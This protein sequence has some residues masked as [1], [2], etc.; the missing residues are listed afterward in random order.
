MNRILPF[1]YRILLICILSVLFF[2][3]QITAAN[4]DSL[5]MCVKIQHVEQKIKTMILLGKSYQKTNRNESNVIFKE[6]I[7][8]IPKS[9]LKQRAD[10]NYRIAYNYFKLEKHDSTIL[11]YD[12]V[13]DTYNELFDPLNNMK[14]ST[15][16][17]LS[18]QKTRDFGKAVLSFNTAI[19]F[20]LN[21]IGRIM[22]ESPT[23]AESILL[24]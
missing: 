16:K 15:M 12:I 9:D 18:L 13:L 5:N 17:G 7:L 14:T 11:Y 3:T 21:H 4:T 8:L 20:Y 23:L 24:Q 1:E 10:I 19:D 22:K 2:S 6:V